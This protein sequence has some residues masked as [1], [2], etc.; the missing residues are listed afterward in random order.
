[1]ARLEPS[2][3]ISRRWRAIT[4]APR[5]LAA[6]ALGGL[7]LAVATQ[8]ALTHHA[9]I[10][11]VGIGFAI[12][13][14]AFGAATVALRGPR[15][16]DD[17]DE[18]PTIPFA[19]EAAGMAAVLAVA[20]A[21]RFYRYNSFPPG[22]WYDEGLN[23]AEA[24]QIAAKHQV[25]LWSDSGD[26][27]P[28]LYLYL[29]AATLKLFGTSLFAM[30]LLPVAA[31]TGAVVMVYLLGRRLLGT[32][33][34]LVAAALMASSRYAA[35]FSRISWEASLVPLIEAA[36]VYCLVR[37]IE[38]ARRA[39]FVA[40]GALLATGLYTYVAFRIVPVVVLFLLAYV[41]LSQRKL[42]RRSAPHLLVLAVAFAVVVTPLAGFT[43]VYPDRVL[44]RTRKVSVFHDMEERGVYQP[45]RHNVVAT[46]RMMNVAGDANGRANIP[47][48]PM[49]DPV[50]GALLVLGLAAA[51]ASW[52]DWRHGALAGWFVLALVP[53][54]LSLERGNPSATRDIAV[55][56]PLFLLA[57]GGLDVVRRALSLSAGGRAAF[58]IIAVAAVAGAAGVNWYDTFERQAHDQAVYDAFDPVYGEAGLVIA[59]EAPAHHVYVSAGYVAHPSLQLLAHGH[60][61]D[62]YDA[63]ASRPLAA[64]GR[65]AIV[66]VAPGEEAA[67]A[68]LRRRYPDL[69]T[70]RRDDPFGR[71][72][73][74]VVTVPAQDLAR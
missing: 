16:R 66:I 42:L 60:A 38:S 49:L 8:L 34:A 68:A 3:P 41:A 55:L 50:T 40:A 54:A 22:L 32:P 14:A 70:E 30:R 25:V 65:D 6:L 13:A 62:A 15:E 36:A 26:G 19:V 57:G 39:W 4:S 47:H 48:A 29:L 61:Y 58:V 31:G 52:R 67:L 1:M 20:L 10:P 72:L 45:L 18:R 33:A 69:S 23:G 2:D 51:A 17:A 9:A 64:D 74:T 28:T 11:G 43:A 24:L 73:F 37:G 35:T 59:F 12:A 46:V 7:L 63:Q 44:Q 56:A 71:A 21:F 53:G 5:R 27:Y